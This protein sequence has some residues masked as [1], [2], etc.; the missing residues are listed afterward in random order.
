MLNI[1]HKYPYC[2]LLRPWSRQGPRVGPGAGLAGVR[3]RSRPSLQASRRRRIGWCDARA[4]PSPT[5]SAGSCR[6]GP[7]REG[8]SLGPP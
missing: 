7:R 3:S 6:P 8:P 2:H 4:G 1:K 5:M